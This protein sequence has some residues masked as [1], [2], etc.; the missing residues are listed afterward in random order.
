MELTFGI[1]TGIILTMIGFLIKYVIDYQK[2]KD[3]IHNMATVISALEKSQDASMKKAKEECSEKIESVEKSLK[4]E[5]EHNH[6]LFEIH[7]S[8][9]EKEHNSLIESNNKIFALLNEIN[10]KV[11]QLFER[12]PKRSSDD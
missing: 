7:R 6:E 8:D 1:D 4:T 2:S 3:K 5:I 11:T 12:V 10:T 9:N